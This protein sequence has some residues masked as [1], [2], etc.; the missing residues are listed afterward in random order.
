MKNETD[1]YKTAP[2]LFCDF[3]KGLCELT[4]Y[5]QTQLT[6]RVLGHHHE[7]SEPIPSN[8]PDSNSDPTPQRVSF[9]LFILQWSSGQTLGVFVPFQ[10]FPLYQHDM[11]I[12]NT[13]WWHGAH[14]ALTCRQET[15]E[16]A[17]GSS[18]AQMKIFASRN[19]ERRDPW[20]Q[21]TADHWF[22]ANPRE[23]CLKKKN[24][25]SHLKHQRSTLT[26][27][28]S[29]TKSTLLPGWLWKS[30]CRALVVL[31]GF[32]A[33]SANVLQNSRWQS[34]VSWQCVMSQRW[35]DMSRI[36]LWSKF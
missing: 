16:L 5:L 33:P 18:L 9:P 35:C 14:M 34:M 28:K 1:C 13:G 10:T 2:R 15:V 21:L 17:S 19:S 11:F 32:F 8:Y 31:V 6:N 26:N 24:Y 12:L 36:E 3:I 23:S 29:V 20:R 7:N 27:Y 22:I 30:A 25:I 4:R